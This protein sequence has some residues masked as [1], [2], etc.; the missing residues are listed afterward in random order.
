MSLENVFK[1]VT[2]LLGAGASVGAGCLSSPSML[3]ELKKGIQLLDKPDDNGKYS[4]YKELQNQFE[5]IYNFIVAS[6][7]YQYSLKDS[8]N[9][10]N[11]TIN[12]EDFVMVLKQI[13]DREFIVPYPLVGN[14][15]DKITK[16]ELSN[17]EEDVFIA[18]LN[19]IIYELTTSWTDFDVRK[20]KSLLKPFKDILNL[21]ERFKMNI[22]TLNYDL[23]FEQI[24]N[25]P[26]EQLIENGFSKQSVSSE[27]II[28]VWLEG[29][30]NDNNSS[31]KI[32]LFKLHGSLNWEYDTEKELILE[33]EEVIK[34]KEP[35][36]I[37][38]S[39]NK[40]LSF[41]PFL[42]ILSEFRKK[43]HDSTIIVVIGYSF[44]DK[45]INNLLIQQLQQSDNKLM[46]V[47]DPDPLD[48]DEKNFVK[49]LENI[50]TLKTI[51]DLI[52]FKKANPEKIRIEPIKALKFYKDYFGNKAEKLKKI[53]KETEKD[54]IIF[55]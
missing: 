13:I 52:N 2:F 19:Y 15:N 26:T 18:F 32:N 30:F 54:E 9:T 17:N 42:F 20:G 34:D 31:A 1:K 33:K 45:Y 25:N 4:K 48:K 37:F 51:N 35:L 27:E 43:L 10:I 40:M 24:I 39:A 28:N 41:D 46:I 23:L 21:S 55:K 22:F 16:W 11:Y 47:V 53:I 7:R 8:R 50:Q 5:E 49:E 29:V 38:G 6:L 14:W 12:I 44:H 3:I 36:I